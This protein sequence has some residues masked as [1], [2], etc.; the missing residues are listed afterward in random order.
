MGVSQNYGYLFGDPHNKDYS[1]LGLGF[2]CFLGFRVP[3][4]EDKVGSPVLGEPEREGAP[5]ESHNS[6]PHA[7]LQLNRV[8]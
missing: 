8:V 1:T 4:F 7:P 3:A 6:C 5:M 2:G